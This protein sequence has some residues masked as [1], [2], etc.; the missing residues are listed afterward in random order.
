V[1]DEYDNMG[2][3]RCGRLL[4]AAG[5][6]SDGRTFFIRDP[7][8]NWELLVNHPEVAVPLG[9]MAVGAIA[10]VGVVILKVVKIMVTYRER[11]YRMEHGLDPE[12]PPETYST[13]GRVGRM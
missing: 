11:I 5:I 7:W 3:P 8:M 12:I 1:G 10:I 2:V 4:S 13:R 6:D 9:I